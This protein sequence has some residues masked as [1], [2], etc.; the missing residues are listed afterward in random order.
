MDA[1]LE[2]PE[3]AAVLHLLTIPTMWSRTAPYLNDGDVDWDRLLAESETMSSGEALLVRIAHE[4]WHAT[5]D[6]GLWEIVRRLDA[7]TFARVV[8]ALKICRG[9]GLVRPAEVSPPRLAV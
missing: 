5:K 4:L 1:S 6:V 7:P 8:E 9:T 2:L 3:Y